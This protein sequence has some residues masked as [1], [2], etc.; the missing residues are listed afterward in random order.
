[1]RV[2]LLESCMLHRTMRKKGR[3]EMLNYHGVGIVC[4]IGCLLILIAL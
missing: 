2:Y 1:M 4:T 3:F